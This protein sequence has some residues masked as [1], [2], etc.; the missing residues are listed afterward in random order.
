MSRVISYSERRGLGISWGHRFGA[1]RRLKYKS[2]LSRETGRNPDQ[3]SWEISRLS[4][5][6][7]TIIENALED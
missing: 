3:L 7:L 4:K 2:L 1:F 6:N 5:I